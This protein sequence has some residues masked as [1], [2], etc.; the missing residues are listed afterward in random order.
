MRSYPSKN[1]DY[2]SLVRNAGKIDFRQP[3]VW[4]TAQAAAR[5][6]PLSEN[7]HYA[8]DWEMMLRVI[9]ADLSVHYSPTPLVNFRVHDKSKTGTQGT[10]WIDEGRRILEK[11]LSTDECERIRPQLLMMHQRTILVD[12]IRS[13][14]E[15][16][17]GLSFA[18]GLLSLLLNPSL[19]VW[20]HAYASFKR[21]YA[22]SG[23]VER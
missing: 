4:L 5:G 3:A 1:L 12:S 21:M 6:F 7:L 10:V 18:T 19:G 14:I 23:R 11:L 15:S 16:A 22:K 17:N 8:F 2:K 9:N 20:V 13:N